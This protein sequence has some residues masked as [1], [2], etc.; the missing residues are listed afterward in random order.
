MFGNEISFDDF[1]EFEASDILSKFDFSGFLEKLARRHTIDYTNSGMLFDAS[2]VVPTVAGLPLRLRADAAAV[3]NMKVT[4]K[5]DIRSLQ[6]VD[7]D[8]TIKPR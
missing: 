1:Q 3:V 6:A 7:I 5:M 8:G 2:L 4:G